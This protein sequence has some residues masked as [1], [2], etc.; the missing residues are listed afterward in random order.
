MEIGWD[1]LEAN[2]YPAGD[3]NSDPNSKASYVLYKM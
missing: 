1:C 3:S 2:T